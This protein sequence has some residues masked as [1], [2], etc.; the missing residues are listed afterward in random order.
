MITLSDNLV[1]MTFKSGL[2][3]SSK[4]D[5][6]SSTVFL[7]VW[8][9][10][11]FMQS[12]STGSRLWLSG[13]LSWPLVSLSLVLDF[14]C[15]DTTEDNMELNLIIM[16]KTVKSHKLRLLNHSN[17]VNMS[18]SLSVCFISLPFAAST[19]LW[20]S[21]L[22]SW[23]QQ[24]LLLLETWNCWFCLSFQP[25]LSSSG[26]YSHSTTWATCL[27]Q[28][29]SR[30]QYLDPSWKGSSLNKIR[31]ICYTFIFSPF[32]GYWN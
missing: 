16:K 29:Q 27:V 21:Q 5:T 3:I 22:Q 2:Q 32:S 9:L 30:N 23:R 8:L 28:A 12:S 25:F 13:S 18:Y 10:P 1:S 20:Q 11:S 19:R 17:T 15:A 4:Q 7:H 6:P 24:L 14:S 26:W 31:S